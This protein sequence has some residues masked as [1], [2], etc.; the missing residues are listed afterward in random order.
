M[1]EILSA[2]ILHAFD[3]YHLHRVVANY[4]PENIRSRVLLKR[5]G[6]EKEDYTRDCLIT[7]GTWRDHILTFQI[8][9]SYSL[10]D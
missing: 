3:V 1:F 9:D 7:S 10:K 6:F 2:L 4:R 8:H 5:L